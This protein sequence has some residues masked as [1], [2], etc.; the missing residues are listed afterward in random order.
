[1]GRGAHEQRVKSPA[2]QARSSRLKEGGRTLDQASPRRTVGPIVCVSAKASSENSAH[3]S[4]GTVIPDAMFPRHMR[5]SPLS[6]AT[7]AQN[8]LVSS[9]SKLIKDLPSQ[10]F[11][12]ACP[13]V[14]KW[15]NDGLTSELHTSM[16]AQMLPRDKWKFPCL[17]AKDRLHCQV[18]KECQI[19]YN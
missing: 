8:S 16:L 4:H 18:H 1:V 5:R 19:V 2:L 7:L 17:D 13:Q 12:R 3:F 14:R 15:L 9:L 6:L 10:A 11:N